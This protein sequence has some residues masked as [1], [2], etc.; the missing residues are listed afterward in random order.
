LSLIFKTNERR[1]MEMFVTKYKP[2]NFE[3]KMSMKL[4][5]CNEEIRI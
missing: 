2:N 3:F 1:E 5:N 4:M